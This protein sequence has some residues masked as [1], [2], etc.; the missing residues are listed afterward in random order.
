MAAALLALAMTTPAMAGGDA[1]RGARLAD[2]CVDCHGEDGMGFEEF[3]R[4]AGL[5]EDYLFERLVAFRRGELADEAD[6]MTWVVEEMEEQEL[7][8]LAAYYASLKAE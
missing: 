3:P 2:E 8:D 1:T 5:E 4:I 6:T 7:A